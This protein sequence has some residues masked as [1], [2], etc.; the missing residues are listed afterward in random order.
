[1]GRSCSLL[2]LTGF[3]S[4]FVVV[5]CSSNDYPSLPPNPPVEMADAASG[6]GQTVP[7]STTLSYVLEVD[8]EVPI[9][10][11]TLVGY[12]LTASA[13][14]S[15]QL[16]WTGDAKV[17]GTGFSHFYGAV[18]TTGHFISDKPGGCPSAA[19]CKLETGDEVSAPIPLKSGGE[20]IEWSTNASTG[21]DGFI[22]T[23]DVEPIYFDVY[24][25]GMSRPGLVEFR[26]PEGMV[27]MPTVS[28]F[29]MS[30]QVVAHAESG[31]ES[32]APIPDSS[33]E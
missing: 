7:P 33:T 25:D 32:S 18:Y 2:I 17:A 26:D 28:P 4:V 14:K 9:A 21:W 5:A 11:G 8:G 16:R 3:A 22:F 19:P 31:A 15:Y 23:V 10:P 13:L 20:R 30:S 24:A 29:G 12:A 6:P 27:E 1:M